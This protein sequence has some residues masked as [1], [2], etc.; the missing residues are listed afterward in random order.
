VLDQLDLR[1][2]AILDPEHAGGH[3]LPDLARKLAAG[4]VTLVQLRDK[5]SD[6]RAQVTLARAVKAALGEVPLIIN[7]HVDVAIESGAAGV[8]LGQED[9]DVATARA[10]LG[11]LPF[12]GLTI[13][14]PA[15][16]WAAPLRLIDYVGIGGVFATPS[17]NNPNPPI[18][19]EGLKGIVSIFRYRM[20]NFPMCAIAGIT[21]ENAGAV[22]EAGA[23]GVSVI[24]AL[25]LAPDPTAATCAL[26]AVVDAALTRCAPRVPAVGAAEHH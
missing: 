14:T 2:Y 19:I 16:A 20:G 4:G 8:H 9:L 18:G 17:K 24:S 6:P 13:Q 3:A 5:K 23:D 7:D 10:R 25:S 26:R 22:I 21:A 12:I 11:P 1:L 15:Q